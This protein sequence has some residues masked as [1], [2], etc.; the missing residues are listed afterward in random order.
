MPNSKT[1]LPSPPAP[2]T[3]YR[4]CVFRSPLSAS[5]RLPVI[6]LVRDDFRGGPGQADWAEMWQERPIRG[7]IGTR[8]LHIARGGRWRSP[9]G[10]RELIDPFLELPTNSSLGRGKMRSVGLGPCAVRCGLKAVPNARKA[11]L[12][13]Q[14]CMSDP[15][16]GQILR[17]GSNSG[18][19]LRGWVLKRT[20]IA[21]NPSVTVQVL[22]FVSSTHLLPGKP[23]PW[24]ACTLPGTCRFPGSFLPSSILPHLPSFPHSAYYYPSRPSLLPSWAV[25]A[26]SEQ[27]TSGGIP[28]WPA[29]GTSRYLSSSLGGD[30]V[31]GSPGKPA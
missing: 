26:N 20:A 2:E 27:T 13:F 17:P 10:K 24:D 12:S 19:R 14:G 23:T 7:E 3:F 11:V 30:L 31:P 28:G 16:C 1:S 21:P 5:G 22:F 4:H 15:I 9:R 6:G 18:H 29:Q 25:K 8:A